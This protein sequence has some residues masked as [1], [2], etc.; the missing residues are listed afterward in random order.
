MGAGG[1]L[2][3]TSPRHLC[4]VEGTVLRVDV[5]MGLQLDP[6]FRLCSK[7][8]GAEFG[9]QDSHSSISAMGETTSLA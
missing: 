6:L 8:L 4:P 1:L 7:P 9:G 3:F 5:Q 2:P